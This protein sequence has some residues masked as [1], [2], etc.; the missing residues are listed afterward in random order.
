M[1]TILRI[2][3]LC[4]ACTL[5]AD[6]NRFVWDDWSTHQP[7]LYTVAQ[8][9]KGPIIEFGCGHGS[10]DLLHEICEK[11]GRILVTLE[12]NLEWLSKFTEK[13]EGKGYEKDNS[14]WHKFYFVPGK[15]SIDRESPAHWVNF[16][17]AFALLDELTFDVCFIDQAPWLA[18]YETLKRVKDRVRF[19]IV[20]DVDYFP[21]RGIFGR[22]IKPIMNRKPGVFDFSDVFSKFK[23]YFP[24]KPWP[25][26]TG[27]PTLLGS[28]FE[29]VFPHVDF[30]KKY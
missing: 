26:E 9:T 23:V 8:A 10:T 24:P 13:Y 2:L 28:N 16:M 21:M 12:D 29:E 14:G 20:H 7:V 6:N 19:V 30:K 22:V 4:L 25:A 3:V 27:P 18:R 15:D 5:E 11:E 17:D 1:K